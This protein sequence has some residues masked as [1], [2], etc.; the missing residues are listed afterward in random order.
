M[1]TVIEAAGDD[2]LGI[3]DVYLPPRRR[4]IG[5]LVVTLCL[6][7]SV[8]LVGWAAASRYHVVDIV[9]HRAIPQPDVNP[10]VESLLAEGGRALSLGN[11]EEAQGDFDKA[12][13]LTERDP[14]VLLGEARVAA[15]KADVPW[16]KL[17]LLPPD[18]NQDIRVS[19]A[20]LDE[21]VA[22]VRRTADDALAAAPQDP[23]A[24]R[25]K[26]DA[27]RIAGDS[28]SAWGYVVAVFGQASQPETAYALA[29]L[30]LLQPVSPWATVVDRLRLATAAEGSRGRARAALVY[31]LG[32]S[33]DLAGARAELANLDAQTRPYPLLPNL[34]AWVPADRAV[35]TAPPIAEVR[36]RASVPRHADPTAP[37]QRKIARAAAA[38]VVAPAR[39]GLG[40]DPLQ[41]AA[42]ATHTGDLE[43]AERTYQAVLAKQPNESQALAGLGNVLRMRGNP[44][45]AIRAYQHAI[46]VNPSY[47][48]ALLGLADIQW[49]SGDRAGAARWYKHIIDR[50]PDAMVPDYVN[51]RVAP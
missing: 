6:S 30:D 14:R 26:L 17:R 41:L 37:S 8:G 18:A 4:Q 15:A 13:A 28:Q 48:P 32:R 12:S 16:L 29:A 19:R 46:D 25:A 45:G 44:S 2:P 1:R 31:A 39:P 43:R 49:V 42:D 38:P 11:L 35:A 7:L 20:E 33:G 50:F 40:Y 23:A 3:E 34:H 21:R 47:L 10:R 27:L 36:A 24:L 51:S 5:A 9:R 22:V